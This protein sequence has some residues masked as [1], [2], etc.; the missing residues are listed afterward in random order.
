MRELCLAYSGC[1]T[2]SCLWQA[3]SC[4]AHFFDLGR[5]FRSIEELFPRV[6]APNIH[7]SFNSVL[8]KFDLTRSMVDNPD[9]ESEA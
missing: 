8:E 3:R 9:I 1:S 2:S 4:G 6:H 7:E 5:D